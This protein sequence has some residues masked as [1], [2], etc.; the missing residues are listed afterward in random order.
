MALAAR[1]YATVIANT[2]EDPALQAQVVAAMIEHGVS[3]L[4]L[5]R[6]PMAARPTARSRSA[7]PGCRRC[8]CC[9]GIERAPRFPFAA[10]DYRTGSRL[11]TEHLL[12]RGAR[13]GSPSS[14]GWKAAR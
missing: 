3:A 11:A 8:R 12:G 10:P 6:R 4:I 13:R 1:G 9:A 5:S 7:A 2:D 14:A